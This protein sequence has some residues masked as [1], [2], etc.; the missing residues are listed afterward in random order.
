MEP[1]GPMTIQGYVTALPRAADE[2]QA[3]VA[4]V[5]DDVEYRII[6]KGAGVD[7]DDH[8]SSLV[9]VTGLCTEKDGIMRLQVR[10]YRVLEDDTWLDD[11][12]L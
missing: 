7:L 5:Q 3:R 12:P 10:G 9:E 4:V 2:A 8:L 1:H 6:P 11:R